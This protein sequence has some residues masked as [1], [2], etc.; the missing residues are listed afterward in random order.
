MQE[1]LYYPHTIIQDVAWD[2]LYYAA[3]PLLTR[4]PFNKL[5]R[6]RALL[7][8][9][10]YIRYEDE[11]SRYIT[12]GCIEKVKATEKVVGMRID[13]LLKVVHRF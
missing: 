5:I 4:W 3:E 8:T 9:M 1:D 2:T 10:D 6:Q 13:S 12:H 7:T 11:N